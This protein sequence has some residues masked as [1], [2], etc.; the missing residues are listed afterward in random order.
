VGFAIRWPCERFLNQHDGGVIALAEDGIAA[1][2]AGVGNFSDEELR[3]VGVGPGVGVCEAAGA[4]EGDGGRSLILEFVAGVAGAIAFWISPLNHET[5][6]HTVKDGAVIERD[7]VLLGVRD[8]AGPVFGA[9][10]QADEILRLRSELFLE[11]AC[12]A[13]RRPWCE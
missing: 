7:A 12:N 11:T 13:G 9:G 3:A 2:E 1:I 10:S 6:D 4:I 8:R 5:G